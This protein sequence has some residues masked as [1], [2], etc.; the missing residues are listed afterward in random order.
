MEPSDQTCFCVSLITS[1]SAP[2]KQRRVSGGV[3][4]KNSQPPREPLIPTTGNTRLDHA[5]TCEVATWEVDRTDQRRSGDS[6]G[7]A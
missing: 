7:Q 2:V 4:G 5:A 3:T 6:A 1:C